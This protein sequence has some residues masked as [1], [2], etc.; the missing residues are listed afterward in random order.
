MSLY[1]NTVYI[2]KVH[3]ESFGTLDVICQED[4]QI[5]VEHPTLGDYVL[6]L[7]TDWLGQTVPN[8]DDYWLMVEQIAARYRREHPAIR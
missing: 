2:A 3:A 6:R 5:L 1:K 7:T 4:K 8:Q